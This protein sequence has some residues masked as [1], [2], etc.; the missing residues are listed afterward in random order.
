MADGATLV[1]RTRA[2]SSGG[3]VGGRKGQVATEGKDSRELG[4]VGWAESSRSA[5]EQRAV[6]SG[7]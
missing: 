7:G 3:G 6:E 2:R 4:V 5:L 1:G